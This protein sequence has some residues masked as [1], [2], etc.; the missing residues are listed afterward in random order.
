M[1]VASSTLAVNIREA[2]DRPVRQT[3][4]NAKTI[5]HRLYD[6]VMTIRPL[7]RQQVMHMLLKVSYEMEQ[8]YKGLMEM[9]EILISIGSGFKMLLKHKH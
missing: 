3:P 9:M 8:A 1:T 4:V 5:V 2:T 6:K 7:I